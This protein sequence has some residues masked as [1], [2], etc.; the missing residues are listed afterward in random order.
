MVTIRVVVEVVTLN[1]VVAY[2]NNGLMATVVVVIAMVLA[3][4]RN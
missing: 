4:H 1:L 2:C 3:G